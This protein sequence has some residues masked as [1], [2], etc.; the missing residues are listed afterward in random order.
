MVILILGTSLASSRMGRGKGWAAESDGRS[1]VD[2]GARP[3][4]HAELGVKEP[5]RSFPG[6]GIGRVPY[7]PPEPSDLRPSFRGAS[8]PGAAR[9]AL[10]LREGRGEAPNPCIH[11]RNRCL[12]RSTAPRSPPCCSEVSPARRRAARKSAPPP[13]R[14]WR[15]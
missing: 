6:T 12:L 9:Y 8:A 3:N 10:R 7:L 1:R 2:R 14:T 4:R 13:P 15:R 5:G 11:E